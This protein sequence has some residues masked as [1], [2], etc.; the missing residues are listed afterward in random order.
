MAMIGPWT[1]A[2]EP[3][4]RGGEISSRGV[5]DMRATVSR[6]A[7]KHIYRAVGRSVR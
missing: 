1:T 5:V 4:V 6:V 7:R 2:R 3:R